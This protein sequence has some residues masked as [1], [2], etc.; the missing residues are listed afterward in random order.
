MMNITLLGSL[1]P[2]KGISKYMSALLDGLD[3]VDNLHVDVLAFKNIYPD[4]L[5]PGGTKDPSMRLAKDTKNIKIRN[6]LNWYNPIGWIYAGFT[7]RG[8]ILHVQWWTY[9][10]APVYV[11]II[12]IAKYIRRKKIVVT[13]HNV[14]PHEGGLIKTLANKM[15]VALGDRFIVHTD[16]GKKDFCDTYHKPVNI[17]DVVPHGILM[18]DADIKNITK[19]EARKQLNVPQDKKVIL[20]FGII[21]EY[22]GLDILIK[23]MSEII[24]KE[25]KAHLII[26]GKPWEGWE[27]YEEIINYHDLNKSVQ[28][29]LEFIPEG[30]IEKYFRAADLVVLPYKHFDAQS[31]AGTLALPFGKAMIV[32]NTGGLPELVVNKSVIAR[33]DDVQDLATK[34]VLV[35]ADEKLKSTLESDARRLAN[36]LSWDAVA[37]RTQKTYNSL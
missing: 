17:V 13:V 6:F 25:P 27:K 5:Y 2:H 10:L 26:A 9:V 12:L 30:D 23:A 34:I 7:V 19:S 28:L 3:G 20:F 35:L 32:T 14:K 4:I 36:E 22:K 37:I 16:D 31:G 15:I 8:D 29:N 33:V 18:P 21:R 11:T 1:P 24:K